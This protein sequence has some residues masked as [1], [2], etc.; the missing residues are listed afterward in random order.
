MYA[1]H[2]AAALA[3]K[4]LAPRTS[5]WALLCG[6]FIPDFLWI[7]LAA[8][9]VEPA[10]SKIFFDDWSHSL[11]SITLEATIFAF[12][13]YRRGPRVFVPAWLAVFS[14]FVLDFLIHPQPLALYPHS[15][16]HLGWDLWSWGLSKAFL[17]ATHYWWIQFAVILALLAIYSTGARKSGIPANLVAASCVTVIG[18]HFI[19]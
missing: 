8:V 18:L 4:G 14:H 5:A 12:L 9:G 6:A 19:L 13:F 2:F 17:G 11:A 16:I 10:D 3:I 1:A 7:G 15:S